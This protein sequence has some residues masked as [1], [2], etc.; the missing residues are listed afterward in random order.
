MA[1]NIYERVLEHEA[2][3]DP[4]IQAIV[5]QLKK[6]SIIGKIIKPVVISIRTG[7][8]PLQSLR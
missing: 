6:T 8:T 2:L 1:D 5:D 7:S 3:S 4:I